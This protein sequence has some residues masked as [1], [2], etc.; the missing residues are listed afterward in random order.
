MIS[1][2]PY[3]VRKYYKQLVW[4]IPTDK[5]E[6]FLSFDDGPTPGVTEKVLD[7]LKEYKGKATFFCV[8]KNVEENLELFERIKREGHSV[9]NHTMNHLNGWKNSEEDY[10]Q[11]VSD[12]QKLINTHLFRPPYGKI[13]RSQASHLLPH[14][15]IIMW[16]LLTRDYDA[17]IGKEDCLK[18]ALSGIK[19]GYILVFHDSYKAADKMLFALEKLLMEMRVRKFVSAKL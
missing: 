8:G 12:C 19:P 10:I 17:K 1:K 13:R 16:S 9:G 18:L 7:L 14:Y 15:K 6:V 5:K 3:L 11:D 2:A 4:Q